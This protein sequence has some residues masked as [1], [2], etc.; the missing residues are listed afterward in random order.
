M[1]LIDNSISILGGAPRHSSD[2]VNIP[3]RHNTTANN[4]NININNQRKE[5]GGGAG[6]FR[7][8]FGASDFRTAHFPL[9]LFRTVKFPP[10]NKKSHISAVPP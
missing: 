10:C 6:V 5:G 1:Y 2:T 7:L 3:G 4:N 8:L 9:F